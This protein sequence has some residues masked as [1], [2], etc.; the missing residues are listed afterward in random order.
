MFTLLEPIQYRRTPWKNGGGTTVDIATE[1]DVWRFSRT[2]I[3]EPGPFSDYSGFDRIQMLI[4]GRGLVLETPGGEIDVRTPFRPVRFA[5]ETPIVSRL[6]GG[7]VEV[8][9]LIG[10]RA[11]VKIDL[12]TLDAG[13]RGAVGP[14]IHIAYC[15]EGP[16]ILDT[17]DALHRLP[18]HHALRID[19]DRTTML[20]CKGGRLIVASI[21]RGAPA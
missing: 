5:G 6:E 2:P 8:V 20:A 16:T 7:P 18:A 15:A 17:D 14:G 12:D 21:T 9:N 4:A 19:T 1:D 10:S 11:A 13:E 3:A